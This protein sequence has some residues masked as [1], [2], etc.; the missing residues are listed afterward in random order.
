MTLAKY[1]KQLLDEFKARNDDWTYGDLDRRIGELMP[2]KN[3]QDVKSILIDNYHQY[4]EVVK[5][6][7]ITNFISK[8][9]VSSEYN[10]IWTNILSI[11]S[12]EEKTH[13]YKQAFKHD[14]KKL[15]ENL[16]QLNKEYGKNDSQ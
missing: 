16:K 10:H 7:L 8:G 1:K 5:R 12:Y 11:L 13:L 3:Y 14:P 6:Y 15:E 4:P 2:G 9:N